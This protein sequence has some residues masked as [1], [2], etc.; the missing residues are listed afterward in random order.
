MSIFDKNIDALKKNNYKLVKEIIRAEE[1]SDYSQT[2][3]SKTGLT[4]P[5]LKN[6]KYLHS[7]YDPLKEAER[8]FT[9]NE[10]FVLFCGLG[11][12]IHIEYFLNNFIVFVFNTLLY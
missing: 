7:K 9:G 8:F 6:G 2:E 1:K 5:I 3:L 11:S 12:G 10:N 4:L